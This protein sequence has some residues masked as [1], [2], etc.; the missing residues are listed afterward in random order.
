MG[1]GRGEGWKYGTYRGLQVWDLQR[2]EVWELQKME[3][4]DL[5]RME[6]WDLEGW[7]FGS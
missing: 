7:R 4:W 1:E 3:V 5:R 6:V 2:M